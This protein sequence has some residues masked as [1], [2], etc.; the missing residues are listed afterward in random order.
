M[1]DLE[2]VLADLIEHPDSTAREIGMRLGMNDRW[3]FKLLD[4]AAYDGKC[5]RWRYSQVGQPWRWEVPSQRS[6]SDQPSR[7]S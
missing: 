4:N 3:I 2:Q 7:S 1:S 5:Q 6:D